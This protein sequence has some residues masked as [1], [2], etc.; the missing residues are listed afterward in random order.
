MELEIREENAAYDRTPGTVRP[1]RRDNPLS[2]NIGGELRDF[3]RPWVMGI[4]NATPDSFY[5]GSRCGDPESVAGRA[6]EMLRDGADIL[7]V[8]ACSTRPGSDPVSARE[9]TERL[10]YALGA[11]REYFPHATVSV[12]T[13]RASVARH[14]IEKWHADIINDISSGDLDPDMAGV[15]ADAKVPYIA[16]HM[17]GTPDTM[18]GL[19][20]YADVTAEVLEYLARKVDALHAAG[21]ADVIV[22]PGF[23]FAKTVDQ[24][25]RL[26]SELPVFLEL[27]CPLLVGVSRKTMIWKE[28][29][30]S[31]AEA[32]NGTTVID[33]LALMGGADILRVHD[34]REAVETVR[35]TEAL[36][37]NAPV[38]SNSISIIRNSTIRNSTDHHS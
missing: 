12:D 3:S 11:I 32:L 9:E 25:F 21:I 15:A 4:V 30:I 18:Q 14:C 22:D 29:G 34:V 20:E 2:I 23:G 35:L 31:A 8:G 37:R 33:T 38:A 19:T 27:G 10:D 1:V 6:A 26:L 13:F 16:M 5:S 7:D 17:R 28:L 24:N 36:R